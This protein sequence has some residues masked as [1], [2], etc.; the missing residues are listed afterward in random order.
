MPTI[1]ALDDPE[2]ALDRS[3]EL[4]DRGLVGGT[5]MGSERL[6]E[7]RELDD[8]GAF[9]DARVEGLDP[10]AARQELA[11]ARPGPASPAGLAYS[12]SAS[13]SLISR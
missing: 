10:T 1:D 7:A 12:A 5:V 2:V 13:G 8:D 6:F 9:V 3:F 4:H 11:A